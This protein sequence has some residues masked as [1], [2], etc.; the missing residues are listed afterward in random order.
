MKEHK[1]NRLIVCLIICALIA[2]IPLTGVVAD[3]AIRSNNAT[4]NIDSVVDKPIDSVTDGNTGSNIDPDGSVET[5]KPVDYLIGKTLSFENGVEMVFYFNADVMNGMDNIA[6]EVVK[7]IFGANGEVIDNETT[8]ITEYKTTTIAGKNAY[9]FVYTGINAK[10]YSTEVTATLRAGDSSLEAVSYSIKAY[11]MAQLAKPVE[12][13]M[14]TLLV[15]MLNFGAASQ[16]FFGYNVSNLA[17][18]DLTAEQQAYATAE[19]PEAESVHEVVNG[20]NDMIDIGGVSLSLMNTI[21]AHI[22]FNLNGCNAE[23][24]YAV[25]EYKDAFSDAT[26]KMILDSNDFKYHFD[27]KYSVAFCKYTAM[28]MADSFTLKFYDKA[29]DAQVGDSIT[30]SIHSY[31]VRALEDEN[32]SP[33]LLSILEAMLKYGASSKEYFG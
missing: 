20:E 32:I 18:A 31:I 13:E 17:N 14:K 16:V 27:N 3:A 1:T 8:I 9:R 30:Y 22:R 29:T 10:E 21:D 26:N 28:Q 24:I 6:L 2:F 11:A 12:A 7:P 23:D 25:I 4:S 33:E 15:D 19:I 5:V